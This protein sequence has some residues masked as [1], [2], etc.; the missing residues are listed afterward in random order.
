MHL[1]NM[2]TSAKRRVIIALKY[3]DQH[4]KENGCNLKIRRPTRKGRQLQLEN[5]KINM[6]RRMGIV[7]NTK[8]NAK[9]RTIAI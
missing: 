9:R 5:M 4:K 6:K 7:E 3:E 8:T 2:K 1:E